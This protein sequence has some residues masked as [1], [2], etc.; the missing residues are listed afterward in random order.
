MSFN[1]SNESKDII[2]CCYWIEWLIEFDCMKRCKKEICKCERRL[3]N[4]EPC[5]Q[6]NLIWVIWDIFIYKSKL[7]SK[8]VE[9]TVQACLNM[10]TLKYVTSINR[11][12]KYLLYFVVSLL[13]EKSIQ[14]CNI[15]KETQK[16]K[17]INVLN[18]LNSIYEQVKKNECSPQT[19]YLFSD[20]KK[21]NLNATIKKLE[22]LQSLGSNFIPRN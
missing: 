2:S 15:L 20:L 21:K 13:C 9:K 6:K 4:V 5:Y 16:T 22:T 12:R 7:Q 18:N 14:D 3:Y 8:L 11:K 17:L 19:A 10:F 1:L